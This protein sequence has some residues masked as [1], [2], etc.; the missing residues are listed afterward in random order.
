MLP[1]VSIQKADGNTGV[2]R[3]SAEGILAIIAPAQQGTANQ[4]GAYARR[5][6]AF[7]EFGQGRLVEDAAYVMSVAGKPVVLIRGTAGTAGALGTVTHTGAGT[8][9][10]TATG[11]PLDDY[12]IEITITLGGTI[13]TG[14]ISLK[15]SIDGGKTYSGIISLGT[16]NTFAV[17]NTG[18]TLNFAAGTT[19]TGQ[20]EAVKATGP[21]MTNANLV[22]ALEALRTYG[23]AWD[24]IL[25]SGL[26]AT[27]TELSTLDL[28]LA[29]R[30]AEGKFKTAIV[31]SIP[32]DALTQTE[33]QYAAA[34]TTAW[35]AA[36]STRVVVCADVGYL[37][38]L[39]RGHRATRSVALGLAARGMKSDI[40]TDAA[41]VADG[42]VAGYQIQ[43]DRG[44]P[45]FHDEALFPTLDDLR[46]TT[47]RSIHGRQ[48][49]FI[50]NPLLLSPSGS[51]YVF[52]Q[53]ARVM[54]KACGLTFEILTGRLSQGVRK[55]VATGFILEED[56]QEIEG[57][58]NAELDKQLV[59]PGRVSGAR[60]VLSRTDDL[61]SNQGATLTGE[62]QVSALAYVKKFDIVSRFVKTISVS[63]T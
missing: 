34:M 63:A 16:A 9:V 53:H 52:W 15:Y 17:P 51:D 38:S 55:D 41:F 35:G 47:L 42:P 31:N 60:F 6:V 3:P 21:R 30:E 50:T 10:V 19:L 5:D 29:A 45:K 28:W 54:N 13:A 23:G 33:A 43:D 59:T 20:K 57:L 22:T 44:N 37:V 4:P 27:A 11:T 14:P 48:G 61:S 25:V 26:D 12:D 7:A 36:S 58:V 32:R 18:A 1:S 8:S 49:A 24:A 2:V 56:A 62:V 39:I 40:S 46:L